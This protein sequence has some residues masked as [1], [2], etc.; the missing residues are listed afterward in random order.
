[1]NGVHM[2]KAFHCVRHTLVQHLPGVVTTGPVR[3]WEWRQQGVRDPVGLGEMGLEGKGGGSAHC[4][5]A[6]VLLDFKCSAP[7]MCM[8]APIGRVGVKAGDIGVAPVGRSVS[9]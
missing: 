9:R 5:C 4:Q 7:C 2:G 6:G 8:G 3:G 1:M